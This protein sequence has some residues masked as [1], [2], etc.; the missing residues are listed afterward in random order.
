MVTPRR[1]AAVLLALFILLA[2]FAWFRPTALGGPASFVIISGESM[3]PTYRQGDLVVLREGSSYSPGDIV[4]YPMQT[5]FD[6]G[7]LVI[8][9]ITGED[10]DGFV[11][12]GDN[13]DREDPWR[14]TESNIRGAAWLHI[15][16]AGTFIAWLREPWR[17]G[18]LAAAVFL[19]GGVRKVEIQRRRRHRMK[20]H[21][22]A[23][24]SWLPARAEFG[25][26]QSSLAAVA[27]AAGVVALAFLV[28]GLVAFRSASR[29]TSNVS[30]PAYSETGTFDYAIIMQ[31]STLYPDGVLRPPADTGPAADGSEL[32]PPSAFTALSREARLTFDY[33]LTAEEEVTLEGTVAAGLVVRPDGGEWSRVLPLLAPAPFEGP[34]VSAAL[35]IDLVAV[36]A[37]IEQIEAETGLSARQY[38]L[39][40]V[41]RVEAVGTRAGEP[42]ETAFES[43]FALGYDSVLISPPATLATASQTTSTE[44]VAVA[45]SLSLGI[46][47]PAVSQARTLAVVGFAAALGAALVCGGYLAFGLWTDER[48]RIRARYGARLVDVQVPPVIGEEAIR[49][50]SIRDLARLAERAGTVILHTPL[51]AGHRYFVRDGDD[52]YEYIVAGATLPPARRA[53]ATARKP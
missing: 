47:S 22:G 8:H 7:R 34:G 51:P 53:R 29:T 6:S 26:Y 50:A 17:M 21:L 49:V 24:E 23:V 35:V 40:A 48:A 1:S 41:T 38:E 52:T 3:E 27:L 46:W 32:E 4:A 37:L 28:L 36:A 30:A 45:K 44:T 5:Y 15:P 10:A 13:R 39:A 43:T 14:A 42:F 18:M 25:N 19:V 16:Q 33:A 20:R 11:T 9:R 31:P 12:R 2:W